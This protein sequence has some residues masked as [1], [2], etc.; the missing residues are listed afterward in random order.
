MSDY[1]RGEHI[2]DLRERRHLSQEDVAHEVG[3]STKTIRLWEKGGAIKW[4]NAKRLA[5]FYEV[6]PDKLV[7][8]EEA[9]LPGTSLTV[10]DVERLRR[11]EEKLDELLE[12]GTAEPE[13][14]PAGPP[15]DVPPPED[16]DDPLADLGTGDEDVPPSEEAAN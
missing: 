13:P 9:D 1:A 8:R 6:E 15:T 11:I 12:R 5:A 2:R 3:V 7:T 14:N 4:E 10:A 16:E